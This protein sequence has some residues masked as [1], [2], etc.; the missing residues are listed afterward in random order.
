MNFE[1][2][3]RDKKFIQIARYM[4]FKYP[5]N[6]FYDFKSIYYECLWK[7]ILSYS[8]D[9]I[10]TIYTYFGH[11]LKNMLLSIQRYCKLRKFTKIPD[12]LSYTEKQFEKIDIQDMLNILSIDEKNFIY[13]RY[14]NNETL[15]EIGNKYGKTS[16][17]IR[18]QEKNILD[19]LRKHVYRTCS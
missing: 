14:Y 10:A 4:K 8:P 17:T 5:I 16:E 15:E 19:R 18:I 2:C 6:N 3:L 13:D 7:S 9:K 12:G 11:N 1:S